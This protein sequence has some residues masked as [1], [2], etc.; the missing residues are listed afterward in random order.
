M[1]GQQNLI[2]ARGVAEIR[3]FVNLQADAVAQ[4]VDVTF[5][6]PGMA[7]HRFVTLALVVVAGHQ[8]IVPHGPAQLQLR[9]DPVEDLLGLVVCFL[10]IVGCIAQAPGAGH[11]VEIALFCCREDIED[12][13]AAQ[14]QRHI[15][16][17]GVVGDTGI[18]ALR[19][20]RAVV[21]LQTV[22]VQPAAHVRL[23]VADRQRLP[24]RLQQLLVATY[25]VTLNE[26][27]HVTH[28]RT[29][30]FSG[31][32]QDFKLGVVFGDE[33]L[34]EERFAIFTDNFNPLDLLFDLCDQRQRRACVLLTENA[35]P[36]AQPNHLHGPRNVGSVCGQA[37]AV[38]LLEQLIAVEMFLAV[39]QTQTGVCRCVPFHHAV[40]KRHLLAARL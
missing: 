33:S 10:D 7:A 28:H 21:F 25:R 36:A 1:A 35:Y 22:G 26:G 5:F 19:E 16:I 37:V 11:V 8:L 24:V 20:D 15:G 4:A 32:H 14:L 30:A 31:A 6:R 12:D 29:G 2:L 27:L 40:D 17:P 38:E 9:H 39:D 3:P 34:A 23:D 18:P 13:G